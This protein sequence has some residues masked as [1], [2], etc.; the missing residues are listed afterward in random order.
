VNVT[1]NGTDRQSLQQHMWGVTAQ[2][3]DKDAPLYT[4]VAPLDKVYSVAAK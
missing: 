2:M 3:D 4:H 1:Y